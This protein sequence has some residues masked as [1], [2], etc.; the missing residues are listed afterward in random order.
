MVRE[1]IRNE[2]Y[3]IIDTR[4][5]MEKNI[6]IKTIIEKRRELNNI[7]SALE[8]IYETLSSKLSRKNKRIFAEKAIKFQEKRL[9]IEA[10]L[11][12]LEKARTYDHFVQHNLN[13]EPKDY[14]EFTPINSSKQKIKKVERKNRTTNVMIT[15]NSDDYT[16]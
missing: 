12:E 11:L 6:W 3:E 10:E 15:L 7:D 5:L 13:A 8:Y 16:K 9:E 4:L 1:F 2:N 14:I